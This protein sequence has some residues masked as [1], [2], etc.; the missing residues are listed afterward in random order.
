MAS[1]T[2]SLGRFRHRFR[3]SS[4]GRIA[5][6]LLLAL[7][8]GMTLADPVDDAIQL[9]MERQHIPGLSLVVLRRGKIV[10][11]AGYGRASLELNVPARPET[12][13]ELASTTK[14]FVA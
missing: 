11:A 5:P 6:L 4:A 13:Y 14:P 2:S 10:K 3:A 8:M 1:L 12:V 7:P 9:R